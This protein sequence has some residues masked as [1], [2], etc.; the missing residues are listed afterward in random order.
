M[1]H[2]VVAA[3]AVAAADVAQ[4]GSYIARRFQV[5]ATFVVNNIS[6]WLQR[7]QLPIAI[8]CGYE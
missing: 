4:S 3:V 5:Q 7:E 1:L 6:L 2:L 8:A